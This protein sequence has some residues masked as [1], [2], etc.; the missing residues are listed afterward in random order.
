MSTFLAE[1]SSW[2]RRRYVRL[3]RPGIGTIW[4]RQMGSDI[5]RDAHFDC[6]DLLVHRAMES[7]MGLCQQALSQPISLQNDMS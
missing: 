4:F 5:L 3:V 1:A 2:Y 7:E 6:L